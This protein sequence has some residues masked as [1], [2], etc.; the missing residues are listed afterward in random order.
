MQQ[1]IAQIGDGLKLLA[2]GDLTAALRGLPATYV[3]IEADFNSATM[4]LASA[5]NSILSSSRTVDIGTREI[6]TAAEDLARRTEQQAAIIE[7]TTASMEDLAEAIGGTAASSSRAKDVISDAKAELTT[8]MATVR[9][10]EESIERIRC[11]SEQIGSIIGVINEIAFQTN[12][13]ALNAGVE[14]ARAGDAGR[15][16]AVVASEVRALAQRCADAARE[17]RQLITGSTSEVQKGVGLVKATGAAFDRIN[18]QISLIDESIANIANQA[19]DQSNSLKEVNMVVMEV[20]QTTQRNAAMAEETCAAC[21]SLASEC[22][23]MIE[24]TSR[25]TVPDL[26]TSPVMIGVND[27]ASLQTAA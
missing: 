4:S 22:S 19:L 8:N 15:G 12:L 18:S 10:A 2:A 3:Q 23:N 11:S 25:F 1:L 16:F 21:Q 6:A 26:P 13:L 24:M 17:V 9:D 14:A 5:L 27:A 20:D 7:E